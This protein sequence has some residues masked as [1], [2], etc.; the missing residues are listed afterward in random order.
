[1]LQRLTQF[2]WLMVLRGIISIAF[3]IAAFMNPKIAFEVLVMLLGA[4][5][6]ADGAVAVILGFRMREHDQNWWV[7]LSEGLLGVGLGLFA[8]LS[9]EITATGIVLILALWFLISGVFEISTAIKLRKEIDN[10]WLLGGAG[11]LS[12]ILGIIMLINPSTGAFSL[13]MWISIYALLF[14]VML[15]GLGLRLK[16][17]G[18]SR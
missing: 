7:V 16:R 2:W 14:G 4:F 11:A 17:A 3:G 5:L 9:P 18:N 1:M 15:V 8:L 12:V 10:E 6:I 13:G